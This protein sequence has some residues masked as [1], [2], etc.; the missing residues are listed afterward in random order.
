V[1]AWAAVISFPGPREVPAVRPEIQAIQLI[2][3]ARHRDPLIAV[4]HT[5]QVAH[6]LGSVDLAA[7]RA[8]FG[9]VFLDGG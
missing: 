1:A 5:L 3:G 9:L 7:F 6:K 4:F 2:I 8:A